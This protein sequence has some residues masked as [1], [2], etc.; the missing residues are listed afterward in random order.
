MSKEPIIV[1]ISGA[2]GTPYSLRLLEM[3]LAAKQPVF[4]LI[5]SAAREVFRLEM[6]LNLPTHSE[7]IQAWL[8]D[9]YHCSTDLVSVYGE[10]QWTSPV[11]S[12][13]GAP[14]RMVVCPASSSTVAAIAHGMSDN[15]LERAADVILK[16]RGQL[17]IVHRETP[18]SV[19][20][21]ENL[22]VLARA[23]AII[24]PASPG[25][26]QRPKTIDEL[27]DFVVARILNQ[28]GIP[29]TLLPPWG[30]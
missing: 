5:S 30:S 6:G 9:R 2:S 13:S 18:L 10:R 19:I 22:L 7:E 21:L 14:S 17:I 23:G 11:A 12:G 25:F 16:E 26:Y 3:L 4:V 15:L 8:C 24:L 28:L 29:Q 27:V 20:H 1:G